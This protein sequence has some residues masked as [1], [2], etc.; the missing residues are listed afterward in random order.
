MEVYKKLLFEDPKTIL[1]VLLGILGSGVG[2]YVAT[3]RT[4]GVYNIQHAPVLAI[5]CSHDCTPDVAKWT[6]ALYGKAFLST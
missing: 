3:F 2:M 5:R 4:A 6:G 1:F